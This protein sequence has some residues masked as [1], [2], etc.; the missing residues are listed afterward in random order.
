VRV[1]PLINGTMVE[2]DDKTEMLIAC[3]RCFDHMFTLGG[4]QDVAVMPQ[5]HFVINASYVPDP[6]HQT[7]RLVCPR[8]IGGPAL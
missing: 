8:A 6:H 5:D 3:D 2:S 7:L 4:D 1:L